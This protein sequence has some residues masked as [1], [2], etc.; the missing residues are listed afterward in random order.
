MAKIVRLQ[1]PHFAEDGVLFSGN[2]DLLVVGEDERDAGKIEQTRLFYMLEVNDA[3]A[4]RPKERR[5]VQPALAFI[6]RS[7]HRHRALR[8]ENP[9][10]TA[11]CLEKP[12]V[13]CPD[14]PAFPFA[15]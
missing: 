7:P 3:V 8:H 15:A 6:E 4:R 1:G 12:D 13:T 14:Q 5:V 10:S 2:D 9:R 11:G